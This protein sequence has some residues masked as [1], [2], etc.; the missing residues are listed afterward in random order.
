M[1]ETNARS[2]S[3]GTSSLEGQSK[4]WKGI[5]K[6]KTLNK[7]CHFIWRAAHDSL[8]T[9]VNLRHRHVLVEAL[10]SM[11]DEPSESLIH[12]LWLCDHA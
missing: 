9:K 4:V 2:L 10:C 5:W 8:P 1:L 6:I 11:C 3:L 12:W 7:V